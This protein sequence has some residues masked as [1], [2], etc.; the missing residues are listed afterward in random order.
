MERGA[1][2]HNPLSGNK[3][4]HKRWS[5]LRKRKFFNWPLLL[6]SNLN[7]LKVASNT[8]TLVNIVYSIHYYVIK[9]VRSVVFSRYLNTTERHDI[10]D[11]D[12]WFL[13]LNATFT[14]SN[15]SAIS[16]RPVLVMEEAG[17][18]GENHRPWASNW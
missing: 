3:K 9:F 13:V 11:D 5:L 17:V 15:I 7:M 10:T 12:W 4:S 18:P 8:I 6:S 14:F 16:W 1:K 2:H